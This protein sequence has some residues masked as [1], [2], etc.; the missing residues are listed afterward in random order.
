[1]PKEEESPK[2]PTADEIAEL[3]DRGEDVSRYFSK[4]K[5]MPPVQPAVKKS[6]VLYMKYDIVKK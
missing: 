3:A 4:G 1:M 6:D 2:P 5:T